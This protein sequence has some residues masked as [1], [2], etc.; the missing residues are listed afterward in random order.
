MRSNYI[1]NRLSATGYFVGN[2]M[3]GEWKFYYEN[4]KEPKSK[5]MAKNTA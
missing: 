1:M 5:L 2:K 3:E 4:G